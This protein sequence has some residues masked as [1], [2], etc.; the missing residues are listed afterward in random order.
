MNILSRKLHFLEKN[1]LPEHPKEGT[2]RITWD[3]RDAALNEAENEL[4][5]YDN[6]N[7]TIPCRRNGRTLEGEIPLLIL[8]QRMTRHLLMKQTVGLLLEY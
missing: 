7:L 2:T 8:Y 4:H 5:R 6:P 3:N 1:V